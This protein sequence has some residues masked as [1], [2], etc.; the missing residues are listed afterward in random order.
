MSNDDDDDNDGEGNG[1]DGGGGANKGE[2][3]LGYRGKNGGRS[4][5]GNC[6]YGGGAKDGSDNYGCGSS[7]GGYGCGG[8]GGGYGCGGSGRWDD[9][10]SQPGSLFEVPFFYFFFSFSFQAEI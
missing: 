3:W 7:G 1:C 2:W 5:S 8:S 10:L 4:G 9:I 6:V